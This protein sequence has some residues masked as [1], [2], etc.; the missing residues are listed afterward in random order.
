MRITNNMIVQGQLL[1]L[2]SNMEAIDKLSTQASSGKKVS[3]ASDDPTA[4]NGIMTSSSALRA[5]EQYRKNVTTASDRVG[6]EDSALQQL[7]NLLTS[8]Q[9]LAVQQASANSDPSTRAAAAAQATGLLQSAGDIGNTKF[10]DEFLF[11][12]S[13]STTAPFTV[14][15]SGATATY[16]STNPSGTRM[17]QVG[18]GQTMNVT[19]DGTQVFVTTGVMDALKQLT[20]AL[21]NNDIAGINAASTAL[22]NAFNNVQAVVGDVGARE[23]HLEMAGQNLDAY[24]GTVTNLKS[25]LQDVDF[26]TAVTELTSRQTAY[27][28]ALLSTSKVMGLTLTDYLQ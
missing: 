28:A 3:A 20:T 27:Q 8:A 22:T 25:D 9:Q 17:V 7:G 15:G 18:D 26:E 4:A 5:I 11:G 12:G 13:Q 2:Q 1:G 19:H 14:S 6:A 21:G 23:T 16:A 24:Q 10:G